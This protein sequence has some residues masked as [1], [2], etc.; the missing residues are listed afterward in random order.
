MVSLEGR[1]QCTIGYR[2]D[3]S[4]EAEDHLTVFTLA[5]DRTFLLLNNTRLLPQDFYTL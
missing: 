5:L 4:R 1:S 3:T 2:A